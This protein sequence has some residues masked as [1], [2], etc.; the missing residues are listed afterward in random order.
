METNEIIALVSGANRGIGLAIAAGLARRKGVNVLLGCRDLDRG[1]T[2]SLPLLAEGLRVRPVQ[3]DATDEASVSSLAHFIENEYGRLD[4]LVN[5]AGIGL[6]YDPSL[7]VVERIQ[8]TLDVNVVGALRLTEAMVPL[9]AKSTRPRIVNVSSELSSFGL[10]ADPDWAYRDFR[11]PTYAASK[12]AL[13]SLTLSYAQQLKDK[14]FKVNAICP[15]YTATEA[16]NFAGTR[17]PEQAAVIAVKFALLDNEGPN[18]IFVN[19]V[20]ELPW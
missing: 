18:G 17:T 14:G 1:K 6:D 2:A 16:T 5:N 4:A 8:K 12:A 15:G 20:Q 19:E 13:N 3:L 10:R 7:S 9:L 11:L